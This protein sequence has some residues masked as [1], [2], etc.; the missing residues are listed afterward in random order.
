MDISENTKQ[1]RNAK[2]SNY[3]LNFVLS[4]HLDPMVDQNNVQYVP[5]FVNILYIHIFGISGTV[6][7]YGWGLEWELGGWG[8]HILIHIL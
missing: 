6:P 7:M 8:I 3:R 4:S 1:T 2:T 5:G